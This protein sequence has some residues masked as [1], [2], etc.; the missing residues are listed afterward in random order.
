V[1]MQMC[2]FLARRKCEC[3]GSI[4]TE[5]SA[6]VAVAVSGPTTRCSTTARLRLA[7]ARRGAPRLNAVPLCGCVPGARRDSAC[8]AAIP[9]EATCSGRRN[10]PLRRRPGALAGRDGR[11]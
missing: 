8:S 5:A 3:D 10:E 6:G 2:H 9:T 4:R 11:A 7:R 1:L